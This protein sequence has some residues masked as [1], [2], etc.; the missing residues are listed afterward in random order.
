MATTVYRGSDGTISLA[1]E[2][3]P[4]GDKAKVI[5]DAYSLTPIGRVT[6]VT[7]RVTNDVQPFH[8]LGQRFPTE[9]RPGNINVYGTIDRAYINGALLKLMLGDAADSRPA[10]SFVS[11]SFNLNVRLENPSLPGVTSTVTVMGVKVEEWAYEV[12]EDDFVREKMT[13]RALWVKVE[14]KAGA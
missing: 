2:S 11:P 3:G 1:V 4:E 8:E 13:F 6:G 5:N 9:L 7:V 10:G 14:D 12:P